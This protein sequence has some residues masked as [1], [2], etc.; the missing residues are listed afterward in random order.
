[1]KPWYSVD[2]SLGISVSSLSPYYPPGPSWLQGSLQR[3]A[4]FPFINTVS[5]R[6]KSRDPHSIQL[7]VSSGLYCHAIGAAGDLQKTDQGN[8]IHC[9]FL[10]YFVEHQ[11]FYSVDNL[12][13]Q[14]L[15]SETAGYF[16]LVRLYGSYGIPDSV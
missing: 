15:L 7:S 6:R 5:A 12:Q 3:R 10:H 13:A 1:M 8:S 4:R 11:L 9:S 2:R 14:M 16:R